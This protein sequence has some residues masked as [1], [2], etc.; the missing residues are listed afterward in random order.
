MIGTSRAAV[1]LSV[2][3][4]DFDAEGSVI[5]VLREGVAIAL[6]RVD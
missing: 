3:S 2:G 6:G 5:E 4:D 1:R